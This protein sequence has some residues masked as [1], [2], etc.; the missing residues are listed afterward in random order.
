MERSAKVRS[1][2]ALTQAELARD[3]A[4]A[5]LTAAIPQLMSLGLTVEQVASSLGLTVERVKE[6][7]RMV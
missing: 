3:V 2:S 1:E 4:Q 7:L 5:Q 6:E